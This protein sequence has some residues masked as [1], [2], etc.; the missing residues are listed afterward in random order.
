MVL[1]TLDHICL[2]LLPPTL[3]IAWKISCRPQQQ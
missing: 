2:V 3:E 1:G